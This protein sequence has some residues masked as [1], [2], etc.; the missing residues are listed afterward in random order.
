MISSEIWLNIVETSP[1]PMAVYR[2]F[3]KRFPLVFSNK[4]YQELFAVTGAGLKSASGIFSF[5]SVTANQDFVSVFDKSLQKVFKSGLTERIN[6]LELSI[7]YPDKAVPERIN[8]DIENT[9][10]VEAGS[11]KY[12]CQT[13]IRH[14]ISAMTVLPDAP[15]SEPRS[16]AELMIDSGEAND[17][18]ERHNAEYQLKASKK[19]F[20]TLVENGADVVVI[21]DSAGKRQYV[22]PSIKSVLGFT[23]EEAMAL[24]LNDRL[25]PADQA[26]VAE[27]LLQALQR[28]GEPIEG[29]IA[30]VKHKDGSWRWIEAT[31]TN[32]MNDPMI[33]GIVSN[34]RDVTKRQEAELERNLLINNTEESFVLLNKDLIIVSFNDQF[35]RLYKNYF[36]KEVRKGEFILDYAPPERRTVLLGI[37]SKVLQGGLDS[38]IIHV[39]DPIFKEELIYAVKYKPAKNSEGEIIGVF[40][41]ALDVTDRENA[42]RRL[43][44]NEAK[45][46][47]AQKIA[48]VGYWQ[49]F[50]D[51]KGLYWSNEV[52]NIWG[53]DRKTFQLNYESY[54]DTIHPD[55]REEFL[56]SRE[57]A[58]TEGV[59]HDIEHRIILPDGTIK[60]VHALGNLVRN[61]RGDIIIF[62]GTVQDTTTDRLAFEKLLISE[63]RHR[64]IVESQTNYMIRM[65][66]E[67]NYSFC[68]NKFLE[69]FGWLYQ[70]KDVIGEN[71]MSSILEYHHERVATTV[72]KCFGELNKVFQVFIDKPKKDGNGVVSTVWDFICLTDSKGQ[73]SE[74]Q[75][76]GID[77]SE[78]KQA[79]EE[80]ETSNARYEYVTRA[81]SDAIWDWDLRTDEVYRGGG[82]QA[83]FG[84]S[85]DTTEN[86]GDFWEE[87]I[88]PDDLEG[89]LHNIETVLNGNLET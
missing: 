70:G 75:C 85:G 8:I 81:T 30:R 19:I 56:K 35:Y 40:V 11:V 59:Q 54:Y 36:N 5:S 15:G 3:E 47:A 14:E 29:H 62:E 34:F 84:Y 86:L 61:E 13:I 21:L 24:S 76:V 52:Y 58:F 74:I 73:P 48:K 16:R 17:A 22:S 44:G 23:E 55:D 18:T 45:L 51:Q 50:P 89:V 4:A 42:L 6:N 78:W 88:H 49:S 77:V 46:L 10:F 37:Y 28:P 82:F 71:I 63:A 20:R 64:G 60:W 31:F 80:L 12:V 38:T 65:D 1:V 2:V 79:Q 32:M 7:H 66:L 68:N 26:S 87:H 43:E 25:H 83:L 9:P 57:K 41:T 33:N 53:R 39:K 27:R 72:G 67:G 69:D